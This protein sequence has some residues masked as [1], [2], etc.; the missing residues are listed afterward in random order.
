MITTAEVFLWGTRIGVIYQEKPEEAARFEYDKKFQKS[1]IELSPFMMPLSDRVYSFPDLV[2][3][4]SFHGLPGLCADSLPDKF[5]NAIISQWLTRQG[6][7]E[8]SF[9]AIERLCYIG[10]RGMGALEYVP[11]TRTDD[12]NSEVDVT[13]MVRLASDVL[14]N[15]N[16]AVIDKEQ[17]G[18]AQLIEIGSSAGGA[19]AKAVIAWNEITNEIKSGQINAGEGFDYWLIKFDG[20]KKNG[21]YG[22]E[23]PKQHTLT[24]YAYYLMAL[25]LGIHMEECRIFEKDGF[26]HF[27]TK[28]FDRVNG[29]KVHMQTLAAHKHID[30]NQAGLFS[31]EQCAECARKLDIGADGIKQLYKRMTFNVFSGNCDDHVKNISFLMDREGRWEFSP[32]YD[33]TF[34]YHPDHKYMSHHQM[35]VNGKSMHISDEDLIESGLVMGLSREFCNNTIEKTKLVVGNWFNY[36]QKAGITEERANTI[37][38]GIFNSVM[39][40][41]GSFFTK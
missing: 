39:G 35:L 27:M 15:R 10:S 7:S 36:A 17:A 26:N 20:V 24:E 37:Q 1:G 31:Y 33:L 23:D 16:I 11:S 22:I 4:D 34:A 14:S 40:E 29:Q 28:R 9:T 2:R 5:G 41:S 18:L 19:R 32:A 21:D 25:D 3:V 12:F 6:R 8:E 13:E 30:Y 38:T